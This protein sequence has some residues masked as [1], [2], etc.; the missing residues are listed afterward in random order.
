MTKTDPYEELYSLV[1]SFAIPTR[2]Y[3]A[4][5]NYL[6]T[7]KIRGTEFSIRCSFDPHFMR[8][9]EAINSH[10]GIAPPVTKSGFQFQ[11]VVIGDT[12]E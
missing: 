8:C 4:F 6:K 9:L 1:D 2:F 12:D 3:G 11:S 5:K 10:Y 7:S